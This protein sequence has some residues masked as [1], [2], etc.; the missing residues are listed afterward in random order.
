[1]PS[2]GHARQAYPRSPQRGESI[3]RDIAADIDLHLFLEAP[4]VELI[5][6]AQSDED[7]TAEQIEALEPLLLSLES[8][9]GTPDFLDFY[10]PRLDELQLISNE[11][12]L[13][14]TANADL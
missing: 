3:L 9:L 2:I 8:F 4:I 6:D 7:L 13:G 5:G 11:L 14:T 10:Q 1:M 12:N